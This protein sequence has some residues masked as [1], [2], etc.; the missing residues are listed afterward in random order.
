[1]VRSFGAVVLLSTGL[2][3]SLLVAQVP[4][5]AAK[6]GDCCSAEAMKATAASLGY[7]D[8]LGVK[9]GMTPEQAMAAIKTADPTLKIDILN[10][11]MEPGDAPQTF[12]RVPQYVVAHTVG[13]A[14]SFRRPDGSSDEVVME[15]STPP[16]A[17]IV[18]KITREVIFAPGK[19][20]VVSNLTDS[21]RKKYG[22]EV[23]RQGHMYWLFDPAEK[24]I[25]AEVTGP[26]TI[27]LNSSPFDG[28]DGM[29]GPDF[30]RDSDRGIDL[31]TTMGQ[32]NSERQPICRNLTIA[33]APNLAVLA[34]T[35]QKP[36]L[37]VTI[38]SPALMYA[39]RKNTHDM[40]QAQRDAMIKK[41]QDAASQRSAPKL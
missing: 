16:N 14:N 15:F 3:S 12:K 32:S 1:M 25:T 5:P 6:A 22:K 2:G 27:C 30:T 40:L 8:I 21:L 38:E 23:T 28:M 24:P 18:I 7:L 36:N 10:S 9:L 17:P 41:Q 31:S 29:P 33:M 39:S 4:S 26:Q 35:D 34:P 20:V 37:I 19:P 13:G 11:R